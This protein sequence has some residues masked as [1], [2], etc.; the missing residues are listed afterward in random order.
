MSQALRESIKR[1]PDEATKAYLWRLMI[2]S[3]LEID[4]STAL[5]L[6]KDSRSHYDCQGARL[7]RG[8]LG[9]SGYFDLWLGNSTR[10]VCRSC[11]REYGTY[12]MCAQVDGTDFCFV[13]REQTVFRCPICNVRLLWFVGRFDC[14]PSGCSLA[15]GTAPDMDERPW[16]LVRLWIAISDDVEVGRESKTKRSCDESP[17]WADRRD[18]SLRLAQT[19]KILVSGTW[20]RRLWSESKSLISGSWSMSDVKPITWDNLAIVLEYSSLEEIFAKRFDWK[21]AWR[22]GLD[23]LEP[24]LWTPLRLVIDDAFHSRAPRFV[25]PAEKQRRAP[26]PAEVEWAFAGLK[27]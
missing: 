23:Q 13:H 20:G 1:L 19:A 26:H 9:S 17:F 3:R 15:D 11:L 8:F 24:V 27:L 12:L 10:R 5:R 22:T 18:A 14:C 7:A 4:R 25:A 2:A 6:F 16:E 21:G